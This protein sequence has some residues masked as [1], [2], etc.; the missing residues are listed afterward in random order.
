MQNPETFISAIEENVP[1]D[2][3]PVVNLVGLSKYYKLAA[4]TVK[5]VDNIDLTVNKGDFLLITGRSGSGKTTLLSLIGGL[6]SP[7][8]GEVHIHTANLAK[9]SD[10]DISAFR[11]REMGFVFQFH[12]L[13][14][15]LTTL[16]NVKL[17]HMFAGPGA[18][19]NDPI[20]L[21]SLVGLENKTQNYPSQLSGGQQTRVALARALSNHPALLLADEPTGNLDHETEQEIMQL[22]QQINHEREIT[23][24]MV[25]HNPELAKYANRHIVMED[26]RV[27]HGG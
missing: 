21:L 10:E 22:L 16:D 3:E 12:S 25:T 7:T 19:L 8:A 15:T 9:M 18:K 23:I 1:I 14:P 2:S 27:I 13:I 24:I 11:A 20:Q 26:G 17:P 4:E 6:T 5:A